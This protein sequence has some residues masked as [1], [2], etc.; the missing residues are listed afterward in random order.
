MIHDFFH[1]PL[2]FYNLMCC[3]Y[4][5]PLLYAKQY[6][7]QKVIQKSNSYFLL[8][9]KIQNNQAVCE[10]VVMKAAKNEA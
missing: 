3:M 6:K 1:F 4:T 7:S 5:L 8:F 2:L 10:K 9:Y